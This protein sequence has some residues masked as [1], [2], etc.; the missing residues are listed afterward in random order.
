MDTVSITIGHVTFDQADYDAGSDILYLHVGEPQASEGEETPEGHVVH[1][2][3]GTQSITAL[4]VIN[5]RHLTERDGR[6][7]VTLPEVVEASPESLAAVFA[8]A[9]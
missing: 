3:P 8:A 7:L 5:A 4:T 1:F 2:A 9:A 6:L